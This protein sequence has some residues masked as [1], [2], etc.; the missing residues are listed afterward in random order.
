[1]IEKKIVCISTSIEN[2]KIIEQGSH[3]AK[4][5]KELALIGIYPNGSECQKMA[6]LHFWQT[7]PSTKRLVKLYESCPEKQF[8]K[9]LLSL[10]GEKIEN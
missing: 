1:M 2:A 3:T 8:N 7:P 6:L 4:F 10:I 9:S 5:A